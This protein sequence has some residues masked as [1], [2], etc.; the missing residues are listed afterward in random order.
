M[1]AILGRISTPLSNSFLKT[2]F[3]PQWRYKKYKEDG[4][5]RF[6]EPTEFELMIYKFKM[7]IRRQVI[8]RNKSMNLE[9]TKKENEEA[10][11]EGFK[12]E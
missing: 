3:I 5:N 2:S 6:P 12:E 8:N 1:T 4:I 7:D 11:K 9:Q 10:I